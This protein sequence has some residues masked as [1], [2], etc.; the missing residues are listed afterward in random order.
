MFKMNAD[1]ALP[2]PY[3][4]PFLD[5]NQILFRSGEMQVLGIGH[6]CDRWFDDGV[7]YWSRGS[8][9]AGD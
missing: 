5:M 9:L 1:K 3:K 2:C 8:A 6:Q 7:A 4:A